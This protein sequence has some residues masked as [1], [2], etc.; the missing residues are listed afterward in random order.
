M[1]GGGGGGAQE[2]HTWSKGGGGHT[3]VTP[4]W[5]GGSKKFLVSNVDLTAPSPYIN[6]EHSLRI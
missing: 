3:G 4:I 6:N 2:F 5:G 1:R